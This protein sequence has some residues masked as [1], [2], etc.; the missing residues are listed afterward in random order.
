MLKPS[1]VKELDQK[2]EKNIVVSVRDAM[3][4]SAMVGSTEQYLGAYGLFLK[5]ST[6]QIGIL[7]A[8]PPLFAAFCQ[9]FSLRALENTKSRKF[10]I[11]SGSKLQAL[12]FIPIILLPF[13]FDTSEEAV[14][15]LIFSVLFYYG[16]FGF[17]VPVWN[18]LIGD[19]IPAE[20][21]GRFFGLRNQRM[22]FCTFL[23]MMLAGGIL[24][25]FSQHNLTS[26]G[27]FCIFALAGIYKLI[28]AYW[29]NRYDDPEYLSKKEAYFSFWQFVSRIRYANF[30]RFVFFAATIQG[31]AAFSAPY[32]PIYFLDV[33]K[34]SYGEFTL[35]MATPT[36]TQVITLQNWGK[37][38]E[39]FGSKKILTF[40]SFGVAINPIL[41]LIS[42]ELWFALLIQIFSGF[43]WSGFNLAVSTFLFDAVTPA[44]RARC[45]AYQAVI[46]ALFVLFGSL[47]GAFLVEKI[48]PKI[49]LILFYWE[50]LSP[51][52]LIFLISGL[53]RLLSAVIYREL[54][55][56]VREVEKAKATD[57]LFHF[58]PITE[59]MDQIQV[60]FLSRKKKK[61]KGNLEK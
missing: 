38:V 57:L 3:A 25:F 4:H 31:A 43:V 30:T 2:T 36:I 44:K 1:F 12:V 20:Y 9:L 59:A 29:V 48:P 56:E 47:A 54:F 7:S 28:S 61:E 11:I 10:L 55:K 32:F 22:G 23:A 17:T 52:L 19:L 14:P 49:N 26:W 46:Q 35:V 40:C 58:F 15:V 5:A 21:R 51:F 6:L 39:R 53:V 13:L 41:W 45:C 50:P 24:E 60:G 8:L 33:L 27:F 42:S 16:T 37:L 18:S 34:M